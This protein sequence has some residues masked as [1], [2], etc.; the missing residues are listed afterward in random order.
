[1]RVLILEDSPSARGTLAAHLRNDPIRASVEAF[2]TLGAFYWERRKQEPPKP[3]DVAILDVH[4]PDGSGLDVIPLLGDAKVIVVSG[5]AEV[6]RALVQDR[7]PVVAKG[8][9]WIAEI[10]RMLK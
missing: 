9:R 4:L 8:P 10:E 1:M 6:A 3:F 5:D 2:A 7:Y